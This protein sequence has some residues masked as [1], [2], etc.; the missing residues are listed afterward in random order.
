MAAGAS[1]ARAE[2]NELVFDATVR[3]VRTDDSGT[4]LLEIA[5]NS[6]TNLL[7]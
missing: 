5:L 7:K 1:A 4:V 3:N 2:S 6:E